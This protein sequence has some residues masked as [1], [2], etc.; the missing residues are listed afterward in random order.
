MS[1]NIIRSV[2]VSCNYLTVSEGFIVSCDVFGQNINI[3]S[4]IANYNL[5]NRMNKYYDC[6]IIYITKKT[7]KYYV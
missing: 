6:T 5:Y 7:N 4:V 1:C 2:T 3:L